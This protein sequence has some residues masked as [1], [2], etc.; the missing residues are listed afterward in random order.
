MAQ[1][2]LAVYEEEV[3]EAGQAEREQV[4]PLFVELHRTLRE[5]GAL[6]AVKSLR[7][8]ETA[9][10]VRVRA[11]AA[12]IV[13]GPFATTKEVLG[14]FYLI[15]CEDLDAALKIAASVPPAAW[16]TIEVR[17]VAPADEWVRWAERVGVELTDEDVRA[18][19]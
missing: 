4:L 17:P 12:E 10:T 8:T 15:E 13:D 5:A 16:G 1:Y 11:G 6:L 9:T 7:S 3:D 2:M 19:A 14:G 18:L